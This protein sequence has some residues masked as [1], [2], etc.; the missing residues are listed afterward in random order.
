MEIKKLKHEIDEK[1]KNIKDKEFEISEHLKKTEYYIE[2]KKSFED[3]INALE[4]GNENVEIDN[5][6][7]KVKIKEIDQE[8]DIL[9]NQ[10]AVND[11][12][13]QDFKERMRDKYLYNTED[14][15]SDYE[16]D[17]QVR[18][19]RRELLRKK[20]SDARKKINNCE[21]CGFTAKNGTALKTHQRMKYKV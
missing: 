1:D 11:M 15:E 4:K 2:Q 16:S 9:I 8:K 7:L 6:D 14:S 21:I 19:K 10:I 5:T 17:D 20:K 12:L 3:K 13:L 18:E